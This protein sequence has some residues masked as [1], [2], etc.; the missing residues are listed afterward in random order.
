VAEAVAAAPTSQVV[1][2]SAGRAARVRAVLHGRRV[3]YLDTGIWIDLADSK[4][5]AARSCLAACRQAVEGGIAVFPSSW[6]SVS[7]LLEQTAS[8]ARVRQAAVMDQLSRGVCF[9]SAK[10]IGKL[11]A[12]N[13]GFLFLCNLPARTP[14]GSLFT[15]LADYVG[16]LKLSFPP[17]A[18]AEFVAAMSELFERR[19]ADLSHADLVSLESFADVIRK[20]HAGFK[21]EYVRRLQ[22]RSVE[23]GS[24]FRDRSGRLVAQRARK[25]ELVHVF[26]RMLKPH[27]TSFLESTLGPRGAGLATLDFLKRNGKVNVT[28][29]ERMLTQLAPSAC[30]FAELMATVT[31]NP[32]TPEPQDFWD[33]EHACVGGAYADAFITRDRELARKAKEARVPSS[34]GCAVLLGAPALQQ[35][36][37]SLRADRSAAQ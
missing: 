5:D 32:R 4:T 23:V 36:V 26:E 2:R 16:D 28:T 9:R 1:D 15:D 24:Y 18:P 31:T 13:F 29:L 37:E 17:E 27:V 7:E 8:D 19:I 22:E 21:G 20:G 12:R 25:E 10:T 35:H 3:I 33:V 30:L 34:Q 6:A 11:E 14:R